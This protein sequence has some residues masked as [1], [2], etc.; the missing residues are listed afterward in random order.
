L[1]PPVIPVPAVTVTEELVNSLL[2]TELAGNTNAESPVPEV[3]IV[4]EEDVIEPSVNAP[5]PFGF[6]IKSVLAPVS[7]PIRVT[8]PASFLLKAKTELVALSID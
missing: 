7:F 1:P 5:V 6:I 4:V 2:P 3:A 8:A